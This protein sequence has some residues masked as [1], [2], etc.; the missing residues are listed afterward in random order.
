MAG[1]GAAGR[2]VRVDMHVH[3]S[4]SFDCVSDPERVV[5]TAAARGIDWVCITDH[6]EIEAALRLKERYPGRVIVGEEVKTAEGVDIIGLFLTE[7]IPKGT[8]ARETCE[9]IRAQGGIVYIP[10]PYAGG[11][12]GSGRILL[13]IG[14]LVDAMEGF[15]ARIH[16][17]RLNEKAVRWAEEHGVPVGAGSDAHSLA[18]VGRAYVEVPAFDDSPRGFLEALRDGVIHGRLSSWAVHLFSTY[19]KV[20]KR[21]AGRTP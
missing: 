15:N 6:N 13:E 9:R 12:G 4:G 17:R 7:R 21:W 18:E 10:H 1:A 8:P 16:F 2:R 19:A 3:T 11:K 14:D 20:K 5:E